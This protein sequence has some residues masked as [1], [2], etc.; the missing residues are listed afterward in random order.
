MWGSGQTWGL[1][2]RWSIHGRGGYDVIIAPVMW[3]WVSSLDI[4]ESTVGALVALV[5]DGFSSLH[6][7]GGSRP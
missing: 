4:E 2:L 5:E 1:S 6:P 7:C 3:C